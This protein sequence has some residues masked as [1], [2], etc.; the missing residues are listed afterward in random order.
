MMIVCGTGPA[1]VEI[2]EKQLAAE[3]TAQIG[4]AADF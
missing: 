3:F 2:F 1:L 4:H